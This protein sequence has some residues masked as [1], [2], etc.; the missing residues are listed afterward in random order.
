M[1]KGR[2]EQKKRYRQRK[3]REPGLNAEKLK[4]RRSNRKRRRLKACK[5]KYPF[6]SFEHANITAHHAFEERGVCLKIYPCD[7]CGKYHLTSNL[8][9]NSKSNQTE[10]KSD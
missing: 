4:R 7:F 6:R 8:N 10:S 5:E 3:R 2:R 9:Y 1:T